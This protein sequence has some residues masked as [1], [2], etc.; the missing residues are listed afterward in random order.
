[1]KLTN[2]QET[3]IKN[4]LQLY[5]ESEDAIHY[6]VLAERLG[7]SR[8]TA[9]DMLRV[10]EDKGFV[11]S[12]YRL[13]DENK[14]G[15]SER[16]FIPTETAHSLITALTIE[17]KEYDWDIMTDRVMELYAT[18][19]FDNLD[20][21]PE[22]LARV[23]PESEDSIQ[24]CIEVVTIMALNARQTETA[25]IMRKYIM[26]MIPNEELSHKAYLSLLGGF[27]LGALALINKDDDEWM[28][29]LLIHVIKFQEHVLSFSEAQCLQLAEGIR[30]HFG[31][32]LTT[33]PLEGL[34]IED[35]NK[36]KFIQE[37]KSK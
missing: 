15:R 18:G 2:R 36:I 4:L 12:E 8:F 35:I 3:F 11:R 6:T 16:V 9:Y 17:N 5:Q 27:A 20:V 37:K 28:S 7:V 31:E 29:E 24:Y 1:M 30:E 33:F 13:S 32:M 34:D 25:K 19:E 10:L 23:P 14:T 22:L 26:D 21:G